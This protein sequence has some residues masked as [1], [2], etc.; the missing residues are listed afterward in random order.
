MSDIVQCLVVPSRVLPLCVALL[1]RVEEHHADNDQ[2]FILCRRMILT[3]IVTEILFKQT[4]EAL[5]N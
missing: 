2:F 4:R 3:L 1:L 5:L